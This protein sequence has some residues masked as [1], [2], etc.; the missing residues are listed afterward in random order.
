MTRNIVSEIE[1]K[2]VEIATDHVITE[3][4][5]ATDGAAGV[6]SGYAAIFGNTD[7]HGD[8]IVP[9]AFKDSLAERKSQGRTVPMHLMHKFLGGDGLPV[10][11]FT[12]VEE[13]DRGLLVEGKI[14]GMNT[15]HGRRIF[16]LVKDGALGGL[17][18][19]FRVR[20]NGASYG[21]KAGQP[22]RTLKAIDLREISLVDDPSNAMTR[23]AEI[24]AAADATTFTADTASAAARIGEAIIMQDAIMSGRGSE[25]YSGY[26]TSKTQALLMDALRDGY[27]KLTGSRTPAGLTGW[28]SA[29]TEREVE[30]V[31]RD[32][33]FSHTQARAIAEHGAKAASQPREEGDTKAIEVKA[34]LADLTKHLAK[35]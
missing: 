19:G 9:G 34:L 1:T 3:V 8:V 22:K 15:D 5:F 24:K 29:P 32:G 30:K 10:G 11:V 12:K 18:I 14:S 35:D 13:D 6:F 4:K 33:G 25:Y 23:V 28:K 20:P 17:S 31:L 21:Q 2:N 7:S 16:D 27:E 26:S